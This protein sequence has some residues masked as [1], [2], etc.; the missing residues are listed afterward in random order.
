MRWS[1]SVAQLTPY[2][3]LVFAWGCGSGPGHAESRLPCPGGSD[4][5]WRRWWGGACSGP[6][7]SPAPFFGVVR[8]SCQN[9]VAVPFLLFSHLQV[10][11]RGTHTSLLIRTCDRMLL[12][13]GSSGA[14]EHQVPL[15]SKA[16]SPGW[17]SAV[18]P[19]GW[20]WPAGAQ[21]QDGTFQ[22][23]GAPCPGPLLSLLASAAVFIS[24]QKRK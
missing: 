24:L 9:L 13:P 15:K 10:A 11:V 12:G 20:P 3:E 16:S 23:R 17:W 18:M 22:S 1:S 4:W 5:W 6:C 8:H 19:E 2:L 21:G 7:C 14:W